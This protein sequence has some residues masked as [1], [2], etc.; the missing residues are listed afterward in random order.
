MEILVLLIIFYVWSSYRNKTQRKAPRRLN[1]PRRPGHSL[2]E[3][4]RELFEENA[5]TFSEEKTLEQSKSS[6]REDDKKNAKVL[7]KDNTKRPEYTKKQEKISNVNHNQKEKNG[8]PVQVFDNEAT[9]IDQSPL[10]SSMHL[11]EG[12]IW[13]QIL[14]EP[15]AYRNKKRW[16]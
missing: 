16:R 4:I 8:K 6:Y 11:R 10:Y 3:A 5:R 13:Q 7:M 2:E 14:N 15:V 9:Q 1:H 12:I